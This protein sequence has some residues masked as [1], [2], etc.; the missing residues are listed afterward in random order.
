MFLKKIRVDKRQHQKSN[1]RLHK[2][3]DTRFNN[4]STISNNTIILNEQKNICGNN[5]YYEINKSINNN[6][7]AS[8]NFN[9]FNDLNGYDFTGIYD[10]DEELGNVDE[11]INGNSD[12]YEEFNYYVDED[13]TENCD[14]NNTNG[15][16]NEREYDNNKKQNYYPGDVGPYFPNYTIFLLFLWVIKHQIGI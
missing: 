1:F 14:T 13:F 8:N 2:S 5:Y 9:E 6:H 4:N 16:F 10:A 11:N 7:E 15:E 3:K 12:I